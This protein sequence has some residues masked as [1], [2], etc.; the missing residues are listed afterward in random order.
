MEGKWDYIFGGVIIICAGLLPTIDLASG[1]AVESSA[2]VASLL[3]Q[4]A[5]GKVSQQ[6]HV[7]DD[8]E[9]DHFKRPWEINKSKTTV[10]FGH[11]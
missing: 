3:K 8:D 1:R 9:D 6:N 4:D 10:L 5:V 7:I 2:S 11:A